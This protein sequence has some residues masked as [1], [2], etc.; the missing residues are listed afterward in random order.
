MRTRAERRFT[1]ITKAINRKRL[2]E[3]FNDSDTTVNRYDDLHRYSK[4]KIFGGHYSNV[5]ATTKTNNRGRRKYYGQA[6]KRWKASDLRKI[7]ALEEQ[8]KD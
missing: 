1:N 7:V 4:S 8:I 3:Y 6:S 5:Y 2:A